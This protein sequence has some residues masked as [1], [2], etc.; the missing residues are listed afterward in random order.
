M[1]S[2]HSFCFPQ[3]VPDRALVIFRLFRAFSVV[4]WICLLKLSLGSKVR[5]KI[6]G[7]L[8]VGTVVL[9]I[10][11]VSWALYSAGSG[12]KSVAVLFDAFSFRLFSIVQEWIISRYGWMTLSAIL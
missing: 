6:F 4:V 3:D 7:F 9:F 11:R 12:V 2:R 8:T 1:A 10:W 5:P